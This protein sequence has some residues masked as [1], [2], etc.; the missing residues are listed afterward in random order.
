M[1]QLKQTAVQVLREHVPL[2]QGLRPVV[3][4]G[5]GNVGIAPRACSTKTRIKTHQ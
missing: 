1:N 5:D 3:T 4:E 2:K